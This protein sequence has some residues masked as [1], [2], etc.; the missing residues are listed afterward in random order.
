MENFLPKDDCQRIILN[1]DG[2]VKQ[3]LAFCQG[4][5]VP[6]EV[7]RKGSLIICDEKRRPK[8]TVFF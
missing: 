3:L 4:H 1:A 2:T 6:V 8:G 7:T 5:D